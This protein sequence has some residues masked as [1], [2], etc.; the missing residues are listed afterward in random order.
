MHPLEEIYF[1]SGIMRD[2]GEFIYSAL[3]PK[4]T[5]LINEALDYK[6]QFETIQ[7]KANQ[8]LQTKEL[9]SIPLIK[10]VIPLLKQFIEFKRK[11]M[12][13]QLS[14]TIS[15]SFTPTFINHMINEANDGRD[16]LPNARTISN[17]ISTTTNATV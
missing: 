3:S 4:E 9:E 10:Q 2:H 14:C 1:W 15:I 13:K 12:S 8:A 11:L 16:A 6:Q 5:E 7:A 17:A